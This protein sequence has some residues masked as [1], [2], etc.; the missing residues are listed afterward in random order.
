MIL[1]NIFK[2]LDFF[3]LVNCGLTYHRIQK[4]C[5]FLIMR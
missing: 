1:I 3:L 2:G 4:L 5:I